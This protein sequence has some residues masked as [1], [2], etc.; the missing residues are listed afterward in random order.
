LSF[1]LTGP[2]INNI[3]AV[4]IPNAQGFFAA[5]Q[6]YNGDATGFV[7][8]NGSPTPVAMVAEPAALSLFATAL[9]LLGIG[10]SRAK[11]VG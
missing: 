9:L 6:I 7:G 8:G 1:T 5:G 11:Q 4:I 10:C 3:A 2:F